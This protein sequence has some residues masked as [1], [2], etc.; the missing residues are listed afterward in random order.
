MKESEPPRQMGSI[1]MSKGPYLEP[2]S[3]LIEEA[4]RVVVSANQR[5]ERLG[6]DLRRWD[7]GHLSS[8]ILYHCKV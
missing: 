7:M 1:A 5:K 8:C 6:R 4:K 2:I 3:A